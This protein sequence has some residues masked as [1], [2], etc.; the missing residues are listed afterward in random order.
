[1]YTKNSRITT[2]K[3]KMESTI[4]MLRKEKKR[5]HVNAQLKSE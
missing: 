4:D 3:S 5:N 1:M 2:E